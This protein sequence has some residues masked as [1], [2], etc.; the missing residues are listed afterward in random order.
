SATGVPAGKAGARRS[1]P[2]PAAYFLADHPRITASAAGHV[3]GTCPPGP[4]RRP[5]PSI[6]G[7]RFRPARRRVVERA[8]IDLV[9]AQPPP[10]L[11]AVQPEPLRR[12]RHV[13]AL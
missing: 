1:D 3:P 13:S 11:V 10:E 2:A 5:G 6:V 4:T 9:A 7:G 12:A 8:R